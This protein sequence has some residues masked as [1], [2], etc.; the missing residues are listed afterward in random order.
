MKALIVAAALT[1]TAC[2]TGE[3]VQASDEFN[4]TYTI[5]FFT[6]TMADDTSFNYGTRFVN[7]A[8]DKCG[9]KYEVKYTGRNPS[10]LQSH[11]KY[12]SY[13]IVECK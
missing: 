8:K 2:Q 1:M 13:W 10:T 5:G 12:Y 6:G 7:A 9:D 11:N 3:G 4:R